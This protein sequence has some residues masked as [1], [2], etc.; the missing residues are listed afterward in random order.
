MD[1]IDLHIDTLVRGL[2]GGAD[3]ARRFPE[4]DVD[5]PRLERA[6]VRAAV[7]AAC[8]DVYL[9]GSASTAYVLRMLA[10]GLDLAR[11]VPERVQ[12]VRTQAD[13]E[14]CR[15]RERIGMLLAVEGAHALQGSLALL[16]AVHALGVRVLTLTWNHANPFAA[17]CRVVRGG[18]ADGGLTALGRELVLRAR[19]LGILIDLAHASPRTVH[20]VLALEVGPCLVSHTAC[21]ALHAHPRNLSDAQLRAVA[22]AGGV[23][24]ICFCPAFLG[25]NAAA[26]NRRDV[27]RHVRHALDVAGTEAVALGSDFDGIQ[28]HPAGLAD[29]LALADLADDLRRAG[30]TEETLAAVASGNAARIL[31]QGLPERA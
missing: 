16:D 22:D 1:W 2:A 12:L 3:L 11:R 19:E 26:I 9:H 23:I 13:W 27:A 30:L 21:A 5:L 17:G 7:W 6:G 28:A 18:A 20:D 31:G 25:P 10:V 14:T 24:G 15:A 4:A 8:D 29:P